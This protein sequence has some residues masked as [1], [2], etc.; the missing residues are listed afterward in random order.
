MLAQPLSTLLLPS[1]MFAAIQ[2]RISFTVGELI[3]A[4]SL[5]NAGCDPVRIARRMRAHVYRLYRRRPALFDT[6]L[7]VAHPQGQRSVRDAL[8]AA[9]VLGSTRDGK[10]I[11]LV[12]G[13]TD[14]PVLR[15]IGR[16]REMTF[17]KVGE[18]R[19]N[20]R[21]LDRFDAWYRHIELWDEEA[22]TIVGAYRLGEGASILRTHGLAGLYSASL[23]D[24]PN[25]ARAFI[26]DG[27][28]LGRSFV[29]STLSTRRAS[30]SSI[31]ACIR[32]LDTARIV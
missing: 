8:R 4:G 20:R 24:Y 29:M 1:E 6:E 31:S 5:F 30:N 25:G 32:L 15:G 10:R 22:L 27:V 13:A 7:A 23:F 16:L 2:A 28:E 26:A 21:D 18:G 12:N 14:C 9:Q 19:G 17:R 3:P 11:L